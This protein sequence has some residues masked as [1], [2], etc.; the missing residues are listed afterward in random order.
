M[1]HNFGAVPAY[2]LSSKVLGVSTGLPLQQGQVLIRP[3]LGNLHHAEGAVVTEHG[4]VHVCWSKEKN[5]LHFNLEIP[6]GIR[7]KVCLPRSDKHNKLI[8]NEEVEVTELDNEIV[9]EL[10]GGNYK[11]NL[12]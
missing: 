8:L 4:V 11:G 7:A 5:R 10:T 12:K 1:C 6:E 2:F 9:F 3:Q